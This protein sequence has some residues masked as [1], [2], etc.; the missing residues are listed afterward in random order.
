MQIM[1]GEDAN[2]KSCSIDLYPQSTSDESDYLQSFTLDNVA[3][4]ND[5]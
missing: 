5:V 2:W 4:K 1:K 3:D